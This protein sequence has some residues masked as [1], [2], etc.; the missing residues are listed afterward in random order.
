MEGKHLNLI[1]NVMEKLYLHHLFLVSYLSNTIGS[2]N[3]DISKK[4]LFPLSCL[5][6]KDQDKRGRRFY[7]L[8]FRIRNSILIYPGNDATFFAPNNNSRPACLV[9][10]PH[11]I[12]IGSMRDSNLIL[13]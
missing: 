5:P 13:L 8:I 4:G 3:V 7:V 6:N 12:P 11:G 10:V 1:K 9:R 2:L